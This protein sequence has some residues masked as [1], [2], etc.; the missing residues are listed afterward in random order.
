MFVTLAP[1][2]S[3][4]LWW[5]N[6]NYKRHV[7]HVRWTI[8]KCMCK[9]VVIPTLY[10]KLWPLSTVVHG[11]NCEDGSGALVRHVRMIMD[12]IYSI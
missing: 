9:K 7:L 4:E 1:D 8:T 3:S 5:M 11:F 6:L 2:T 10:M 12:S